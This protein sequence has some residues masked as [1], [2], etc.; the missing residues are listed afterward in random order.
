MKY[1]LILILSSILLQC[2]NPKSNISTTDFY[3][4]EHTITYKNQDLPFG[5]PVNECLNYFINTITD[6]I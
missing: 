2:Q 6:F 3:I 5:K 1:S 4:S